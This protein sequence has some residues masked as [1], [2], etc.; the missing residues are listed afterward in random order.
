MSLVTEKPA[1]QPLFNVP[2]Q[3]TTL[4]LLLSIVLFGFVA[5]EYYL[6]G[7]VL[8]I[9]AASTDWL[10]GY[11]ARKYGQVTN[12]GRILDPF[13]DKI[14]ICGTFIFLAAVPGSQIVPWMAVVI[15][16][17][18]LLV[19]ALRSY[20]EGEGADFSA[21]MA[22]KLKMVLQ[23]VAAG[24]SLFL[25]SYAD[26]HPSWLDWATT[27]SVWGAILLTLYSGV[28]YIQRAVQ[29]LRANSPGL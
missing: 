28:G 20:L 8:F 26:T 23:C 11:W 21:N 1:A 14:I 27:L 15:V 22:G 2:N 7:L 17:R 24:L 25:L 10:D 13:V 18:E 3:L 16:G 9:I 6:T 12:L 19:T 5:F 4:R 29:L